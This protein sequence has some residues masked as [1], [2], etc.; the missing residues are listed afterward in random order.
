[1]GKLNL[2]ISFRVRRRH[3]YSVVK[4]IAIEFAKSFT[5]YQL[6]ISVIYKYEKILLFV[7]IFIET[8]T[9]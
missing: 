5:D 8:E 3:S 6:N 2:A 1:M 9:F 4:V 7:V